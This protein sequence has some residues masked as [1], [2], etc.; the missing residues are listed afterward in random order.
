MIPRPTV[1][2]L[3][4]NILEFNKPGKLGHELNIKKLKKTLSNI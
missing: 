3:K 2:L 4:T 1:Q